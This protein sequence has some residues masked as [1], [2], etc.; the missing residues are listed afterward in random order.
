MMLEE[1]E[2][3]RVPYYEPLRAFGLAMACVAWAFA[4]QREENSV[5]MLP[6][7]MQWRASRDI[8]REFAKWALVFLAPDGYR[9]VQTKLD[10]VNAIR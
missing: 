10:N 8:R 7:G 1:I 3:E 2:V 5:K 9:I 6:I 4:M